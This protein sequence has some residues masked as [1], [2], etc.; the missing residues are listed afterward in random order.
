MTPFDLFLYG[1]AI[2]LSLLF[3]SIPI[4]FIYDQLVTQKRVQKAICKALENGIS[5]AEMAEKMDK[6]KAGLKK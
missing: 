6:V 5:P 4:L 2:A 1:V 3:I